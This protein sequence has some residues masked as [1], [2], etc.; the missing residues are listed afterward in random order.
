MMDKDEIDKP[1]YSICLYSTKH[2]L[3]QKYFT[4]SFPDQAAA[5]ALIWIIENKEAKPND[6]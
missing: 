4:A 5:E 1:P 3:A 6:N 2:G